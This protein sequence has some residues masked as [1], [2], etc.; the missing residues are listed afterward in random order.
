[1]EIV[2]FLIK[3][4]LLF[5]VHKSNNKIFVLLD[6]THIQI[7]GCNNNAS[8]KRTYTNPNNLCLILF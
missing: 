1:L 2:N 3:F 5:L 6:D 4:L 8:F 7:L